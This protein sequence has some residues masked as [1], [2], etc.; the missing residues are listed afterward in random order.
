MKR[1]KSSGN[2]TNIGAVEKA[3]VLGALALVQNE[4]TRYA[5]T[6]QFEQAC[7]TAAWLEQTVARKAK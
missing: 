3:F 1:S 6:L 4:A 2:A 5:L 7:R